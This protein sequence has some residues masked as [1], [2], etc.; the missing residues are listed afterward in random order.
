MMLA[1]SNKALP[2][3]VTLPRLFPY[4]RGA[5]H[6]PDIHIA[7]KLQRMLLQRQRNNIWDDSPIRLRI[8]AS[9]PLLPNQLSTTALRQ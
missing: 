4:F 2:T 6:C 3:A 9:S 1:W 5:E 8:G 7:G